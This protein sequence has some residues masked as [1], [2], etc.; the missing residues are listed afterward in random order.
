[1]NSPRYHHALS[2]EAATERMTEGRRVDN[3]VINVGATHMK[4]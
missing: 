4:L 1:M 3:L 2:D